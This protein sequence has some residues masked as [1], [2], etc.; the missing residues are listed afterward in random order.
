MASAAGTRIALFLNEPLA[1]AHTTGNS[2]E[3]FTPVTCWALSA[4]SS[5][6]TPAVFLAASLVRMATSSR[7]VAMSSRSVNRVAPAM[8]TPWCDGAGIVPGAG[9]IPAR[10]PDQPRRQDCAVAGNDKAR[11]SPGPC[12]AKRSNLDGRPLLATAI[13]WRSR[14][15]LLADHLLVR[16]QRFGQARHAIGAGR[17]AY[18]GA[19]K[20]AADRLCTAAETLRQEAFGH[21]I[22]RL[23]VLR[24]RETVAFVG[25]QHVRHRDVVGGH[26]LDDLVGLVLL[27]P[28]IVGALADQQRLAD[29]VG[30]G[31]RRTLGEPRLAFLGARV[32]HA[33]GQ[34]LVEARPVRRYRAQQRVEVG[35]ADNVDAASERVGGEGQPGKRRVATVAAAHDRDLV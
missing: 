1:T 23:A 31:Q 21:R 18:A 28:R 9:V 12:V 3:A 30:A 17:H 24:P 6:R 19:F 22:E 25:E 26:R 2:R 7:R 34:L 29:P 8:R 10:R 20:V 13:R 4:R 27:D 11:A 35:G 32:A 16:V 14:V 15:G 5:P 33:L